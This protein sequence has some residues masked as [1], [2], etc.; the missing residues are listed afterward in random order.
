MNKIKVAFAALTAIAGIG[1]A[2]AFSNNG[3]NRANTVYKW[4]TVGG[5]TLLQTTIP[6]AQVVCPEPSG[7]TCLRGTAPQRTPVTLFK[8]P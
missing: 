8:K 6:S 7:V 1:G 3:G 2:Y 5:F 4:H